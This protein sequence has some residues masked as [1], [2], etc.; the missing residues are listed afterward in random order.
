MLFNSNAFYIFFP[1][2]F[3][4]YWIIP[5]KYRWGVLLISSYYF[6]MS[7]NIKYVTLILTTTLV[8]YCAA[9]LMERTESRRKKKLCLTSALLISFGILFF[10]KYFNFLSKSVT[11]VLQSFAIPVGQAT[12]NLM[13]PV[14]ISFYTFQTLSYVIDVYRGEVKACRHFGKYATFI[15]FFPQL[16]AGPIERTRNLLPQIEGEHTFHTEKGIRGAK[17]I[18]WGFFKKIAIADTVAI[19][20]DTVYNAAESFTGFP[21]L[22]ATVLFTFQIYCDFSG[23]SDIA[24]GTAGLLDIDLMINFKSPYFSASIREFWSRWHISLSTWFRDYVYIPLGGNRRGPWRTRWNLLVTFLVSGL[25]HGA[26]WTY[27]LWGGIHGLGQI[28]EREWNRMFRIDPNKKTWLKMG[29]TFLFVSVTWIFFRANTISDAGYI[30]THL[31]DG[32]TDPKA[33]LTDG[34]HAFQHAGM[35]QVPGLSTLI[36]SFL[37]ILILLLHDRLNQTK[38]VWA[39]IGGLKK[40]LR[41]ALYFL[42]LFIILYSRQLGEYEF[43]YFQF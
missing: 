7:W 19:Y 18:A 31:F 10:F 24:V 21:L 12:L 39:R 42:L 28:L 23:Y 17:M 2:V 35:V 33:Y 38:D 30:L 36:I 32:I 16:V 15:S 34:Y 20:V 41:Y 5:A 11:D 26:D 6:Y 14:G 3:T 27:V 37:C 43:V 40:P 13:L 25:W 8:S 29:C 1:I 9:L 4:V 22:L